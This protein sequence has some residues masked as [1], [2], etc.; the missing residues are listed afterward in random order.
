MFLRGRAVNACYWCNK[1]LPERRQCTIDH[2]TPRYFDAPGRTVI[3]C[4]DCNHSRG[5][6][7]SFFCWQTKLLA[8]IDKYD[9]LSLNKKHILVKSVG[10]FRGRFEEILLLHK[11]WAELEAAKGVFL[12]IKFSPVWEDFFYRI[13]VQA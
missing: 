12:P 10:R 8:G 2:L 13:G 5:L 9:K 4:Y 6:V 3:A 11:K 1:I 7:L